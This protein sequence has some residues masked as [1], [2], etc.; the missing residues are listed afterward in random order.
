MTGPLRPPKGGRP[1]GMWN[2]ELTFTLWPGEQA[3]RTGTL[4]CRACFNW[5]HWHW[6]YEQGGTCQSGKCWCSWRPRNP[7]AWFVVVNYR[8]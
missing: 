3:A 7:A 8:R 1:D 6:P 5:N 2:F 4:L